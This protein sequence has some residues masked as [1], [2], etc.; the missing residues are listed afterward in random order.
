MVLRWWNRLDKTYDN[1]INWNNEKTKKMNNATIDCLYLELQI[2]QL[3]N[4]NA[5]L[6]QLLIGCNIAIRYAVTTVFKSS[7]SRDM[8]LDI[9]IDFCMKYGLW[10]SFIIHV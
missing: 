2:I 3:W 8:Q 1:F 5:I 4:K 6:Q 10:P 7:W 9:K